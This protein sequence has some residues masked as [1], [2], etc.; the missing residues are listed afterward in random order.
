MNS[1][2]KTVAVAMATAL[3]VS[4]MMSPVAVYAQEKLVNGQKRIEESQI[5]QNASQQPITIDNGGTPISGDINI[6]ETNFPDKEFRDWIKTHIIGADNDVLTPDEI[7]NITRIDVSNESEIKN[8]KGIEHFTALKGL[9]CHNTGITTLDVSKNVLLTELFCGGTGI[10]T[11]DVSNN[12]KLIYLNCDDTGITTLDVSNN[13]QL[14]YLSCY[15]TGITTLDV[16]K[17]DQ[18]TELYCSHTGITTLDVSNNKQ[19]TLLYCYNTGITTLD[20]SNNK[21]LTELICYNTGITTLDISKNKQLTEL[22]CNNTSITTLNVRNNEQLTKLI[23]DH[24]G[25]TTLNVRNNEQLTKLI[26]DHTGITTLD[27]SKNKQLTLLYCYN[28]GI[29]TMDVSNNEQLTYLACYNTGITTLDV[30]NNKQLI[31]LYCTNT[32]LAF[33][34][35]GSLNASNTFIVPSSTTASLTVAS[36][37][38][39]ITQAFAGIDTTK[40]SNIQGAELDGNTVKGYS[41]GTPITY[42]Y[43]CGTNNGIPVKLDVTLNLSI[44]KKSS[45]IAITGSLDTTYTGKPI[46]KPTIS[47][48]GSTGDV[49]FA[50]QVKNGDTWETYNDTPINAGIYRVTA[51]LTE[52]DFY[53]DAET[54]K[55]YTISPKDIKDGNITVSNISNDSDVEKLIVKD[56]DKVLVKGTDYDVETKMDGSKT[57][58]TIT[59]KGNYVG[60]IEKNYTVKQEQ[61]PQDKPKDTGSVKTSDSTQTGLLAMLSMMSAGCI[62]LLA[63]KKRKKNMKEDETTPL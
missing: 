39:D 61:K 48:T 14:I 31:D 47:K 50:Y 44:S 38:F 8:L 24:T 36:A 42:T 12:K 1:K 59:F 30:S 33:L 22:D 53:K 23:C 37:S 19:L 18:L 43:N 5:K 27:I 26:C 45:T 28:T 60:T 54:T 34:K 46:E 9:Y 7:S 20:V 25:I 41:V 52:D 15:S 16:R 21:Q 4:G 11:L 63:G 51:H 6:N 32:P 62:A 40:I 35:L 2:K 17:N 10:I 29:T 56:D 13:E 49:T 3:G 57:T 58:V 55:E